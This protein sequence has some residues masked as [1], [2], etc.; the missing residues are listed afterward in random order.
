M[1][2]RVRVALALG[3]LSLEFA[4][5]LNAATGGRAGEAVAFQYRRLR[6]RYVTEPALRER[7]T[8]R[9]AARAI[10][11]AIELTREAA[12]QHDD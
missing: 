9:D 12:E 1:S 7:Q 4:L 3:V 6:W 2:D 8:R 11:Q 5:L 10:W